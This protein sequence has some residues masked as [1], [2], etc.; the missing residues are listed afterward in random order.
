MIRWLPFLA[1]LALALLTALP[2]VGRAAAQDVD[3]NG[4]AIPDSLFMARNHEPISYVTT[5][6]RDL[7]AGLWTQSLSYNHNTRRYAFG[8]Q[9]SSNT[10]EGLR[11]LSTQGIAGNLGGTFTLKATNRW[12]WALDGR[13][14]M[15]STEDDR[16]KTDRRQSRLQLRTQ[17]S[18]N[19]SPNFSGV[20]ILFGELQGDN[21]L[22]S[23]TIPGQQRI[24]VDSSGVPPDTTIYKSHA[25]RD[26]SFTSG[27]RDG[28]SG[29]IHWTPAKWLDVTGLGAATSISSKTKTLTHDYWAFNPGEGAALTTDSLGISTAPNGD[30]R[31]NIKTSYT[32]IRKTTMNFEVRNMNSDQE[33]FSLT[34]R[35]QE[36]LAY[37][38]R[39]AVFH[40][41]NIPMTSAVFS[42]DASV[43]RSNREY[44]LQNNLNSLVKTGSVSANF[45]VYRTESRASLGF[46]AGR[47]RND[48][49]ITQNGLVL[50]RALT[51]GGARRVTKR[52]W[53]DG[54]GSL[55]LFSRIYDDSVSDRDDVRG[56]GSLGGGYHVSDR[57]STTV[58]FSTTRAH[59]VAI[60]ASASGGNN[61]Q[62]T[63]QMDATL[64]LLLSRTFTI[65]QNY[66]INANYQ[67]YDYDEPRNSL[68]R[69]RRIDTVLQ[70]SLFSFGSIRLTHN[71][72]FQDR[73]G[74]SQQG[75]GGE[76][77][78]V[79]A[80]QLYQQNLSVTVGI[81]P[82]QGVVV[83]ATQ[84]LANTR[85]YITTPPVTTNRNRWNLNVGA[86]VD[87]PLPGDMTLQGMVQHIGEYTELPRDLPSVEQVDYWIAQ[88]QFS[89][90][91]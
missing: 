39:G 31:F 23:R 79:I 83:A 82:F 57:C 67:I 37:G 81:R 73:G 89:K 33:F 13:A 85:T 77:I 88:V 6:N 22:G 55:T 42:I 26:S 35:G 86:T 76:R 18:F 16:S 15:N 1:A 38:D 70:D 44:T 68:T 54:T 32:G 5:Y 46:E 41:E 69:I 56:Y 58:H 11:G 34:K 48:R 47:T 72:F 40:F 59:A 64:N 65:L 75:E 14:N 74:Y 90:D 24:D 43:G 3:E 60:D 27:F 4:E 71:F 30:Q 45:M 17:Y 78:Y 51:A 62:S 80:Q 66:Q 63:Y 50:D 9:G 12:L 29:S 21:S 49:Q 20:G 2:F 61:V 52:L 28:L 19:P 53:L 25:S 91:F 10:T 8:L 87:R 36:H 7:S 84:S